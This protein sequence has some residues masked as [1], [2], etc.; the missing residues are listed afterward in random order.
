ML[1]ILLIVSWGVLGYVIWNLNNKVEVYEDFCVGLLNETR[2]IL[3]SIKATD[4]RGSFEADDEVGGAFVDIKNII[5]KLVVFL[6]EEE[7]GAETKK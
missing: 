5:S 3:D 4:I 2:R 1:W 6:D 7:E